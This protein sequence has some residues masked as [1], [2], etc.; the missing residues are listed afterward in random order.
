MAAAGKRAI[1][2]SQN[3]FKGSIPELYK[4]HGTKQG[5]PVLE[6]A[7]VSLMAEHKVPFYR[8]YEYFLVPAQFQGNQ[9]QYCRN[10]IANAIKEGKTP[11]MNFVAAST[12]TAKGWGTPAR[13]TDL[14]FNLAGFLVAQ[15]RFR[16]PNSPGMAW[17]KDF[18]GFDKERSKGDISCSGTRWQD[19]DNAWSEVKTAYSKDYGTPTED[20]TEASPGVFTREYTKASITID[21]KKKSASITMK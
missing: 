11:G 12:S 9:W 21:C 17:G 16:G 4:V 14:N 15:S 18:F 2:S 13:M 1:L 20:A 3:G 5:C 7:A 10:Q 6:D 8:F 19:C